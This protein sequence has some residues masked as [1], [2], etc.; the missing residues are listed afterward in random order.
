MT[1]EIAFWL[2]A[3]PIPLAALACSVFAHEI[4]TALVPRGEI[5]ARADEL[6]A[7]HG[8]EAP[9]AARSKEAAAHAR[10]DRLEQGVWRRV[11]GVLERRA[12]G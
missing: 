7:R 5:A 9:A 12:G 4:R 1:A 8:A 6:I 10:G 2:L 3:L 11:A